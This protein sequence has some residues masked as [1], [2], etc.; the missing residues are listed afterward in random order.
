MQYGI[1]LE[2]YNAMVVAQGGVCKI[3]GNPPNGK[4]LVVDHCHSLTKFR[5]LLCERC[6]QGLGSFKDNPHLLLSAKEYLEE[7]YASST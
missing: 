1:T 6:N 7:F 2:Q 5:G 3:C 4:R